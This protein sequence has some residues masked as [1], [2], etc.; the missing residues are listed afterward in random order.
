MMRLSHGLFAAVVCVSPSALGA[1]EPATPPSTIIV[2]TTPF[3]SWNDDVHL[4]SPGSSIAVPGNSAVAWW[5]LG[6]G[7][8]IGAAAALGVTQAFCTG[9]D[10]CV[11]R[12]IGA[13]LMGSLLGG[14]LES[15][16][17]Y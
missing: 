15:G 6:R 17:D 9:S 5:G 1:Q 11:G 8:T 14:A 10:G 13:V 3:A 4:L 12:T 7:A 16:M 2:R